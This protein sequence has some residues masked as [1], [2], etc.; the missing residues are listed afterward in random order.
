M[1]SI[2]SVWSIIPRVLQIWG[3]LFLVCVCVQ[4]IL[5][6]TATLK[7]SEF[8]MQALTGIFLDLIWGWISAP[9][10]FKNE[11]KLPKM[12][13]IV[14][15]FLVLHFC[16]NFMKIRTKIPKLQIHENLHKNVNEN[17]FSFTFYAIFLVFMVGN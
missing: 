11:Q 5:K 2:V 12:V 8:E 6:G 17:M 4:Q 7:A 1:K 14:P 13:Y 15:N 10:Q 9:S 16:E 3:M